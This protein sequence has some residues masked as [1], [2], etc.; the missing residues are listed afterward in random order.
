MKSRTVIE[1]YATRK[2]GVAA[3]FLIRVET[4]APVPPDG[5]LINIKGEDYLVLSTNYSI[6]QPGEPFPEVV[7]RRNVFMRLD[8]AE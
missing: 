6:D 2:V 4:D 8:D 7:Y 3:S 5:A 1:F